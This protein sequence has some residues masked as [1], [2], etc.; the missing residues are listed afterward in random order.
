ML[1]FETYLAS[2]GYTLKYG[3]LAPFNT[4]DNPYRQWI[5]D[6]FYIEIGLFKPPMVY[7]WDDE[8]NSTVTK[9]GN[10]TFI[11]VLTSEGVVNIPT[12]NYDYYESIAKTSL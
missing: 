7:T 8:G 4:Y 9:A 3:K 12:E 6:G 10:Q 5:K 2:V 11:G 1:A